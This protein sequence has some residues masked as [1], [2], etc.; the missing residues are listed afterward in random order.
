M[1][2]YMLVPGYYEKEVILSNEALEIL[3][4]YK[5]VALFASVQFIHLD[6]VQTQLNAKGISVIFTHGKRTS[7]KFQLLGCDCFSGTY[8]DK[9]I[10]EKSDAILYIGDGLF[11]PRALL[12]AQRESE[13]QKFWILFD[14]IAETV[15]TM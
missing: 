8:A 15:K 5:T 2:D 4:K 9:S 10:F 13:S 3:S 1:V 12:L 7:G 14:P 11:H 6:T